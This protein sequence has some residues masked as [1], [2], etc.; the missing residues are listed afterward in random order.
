MSAA[1]QTT[2]T[3]DMPPLTAFFSSLSEVHF[4]APLKSIADSLYGISEATELPFL[5]SSVKVKL[6]PAK[7]QTFKEK[8]YQNSGR[9]FG[10]VEFHVRLSQ[11]TEENQKA[12]SAAAKPEDF[13]A[14]FSQVDILFSGLAA[15][16]DKLGLKLRRIP[17]PIVQH[18]QSCPI[19]NAAKDPLKVLSQL[20]SRLVFSNPRAANSGQ[21]VLMTNEFPVQDL[22]LLRQEHPEK[23]PTTATS[24]SIDKFFAEMLP[25]CQEKKFLVGR[26]QEGEAEAA[27]EEKK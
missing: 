7:L 11:E 27:E 24:D 9:K 17:E 16:S 1:P 2:T 25:S 12:V 5:P 15:S 18:L 6:V 19:V 10:F 23:F 13:E 4:E 26:K 22:A 14:L 21:T 20:T 3:N 8:S